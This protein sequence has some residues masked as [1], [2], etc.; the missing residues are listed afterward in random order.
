ML[1]LFIPPTMS[2]LSGIQQD[3]LSLYRR[4]LRASTKKDRHELAAVYISEPGGRSIPLTFTALL[5]SKIRTTHLSP[6]TSTAHQQQQAK[7]PEDAPETT[8]PPPSSTTTA[9][10]AQE[11]RR[12]AAMVK[13]SDFKKVEYMLR[14]GDKQ[15]KL[16]QMPGVKL[17]SGVNGTQL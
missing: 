1:D 3:V 9:F 10:A 2:R 15:I 16:L 8:Q 14:K 7:D 5:F 6:L 17:V 12:Q 4:V 11:F 13:R